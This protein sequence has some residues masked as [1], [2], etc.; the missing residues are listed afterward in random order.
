MSK[1]RA[2]AKAEEYYS[3]KYYSLYSI[4]HGIKAISLIYNLQSIWPK[5]CDLIARDLCHQMGIAARPFKD[6]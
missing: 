5:E 3:C 4:S 1:I 6:F 2:V